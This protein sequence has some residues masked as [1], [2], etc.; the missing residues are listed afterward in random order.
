MAQGLTTMS[1]LNL[2][3]NIGSD[4]LQQNISGF[5]PKVLW[6]KSSD[7]KRS[8]PKNRRS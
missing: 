3:I 5:A 7:S 1:G 8:E 4:N 6:R 2:A